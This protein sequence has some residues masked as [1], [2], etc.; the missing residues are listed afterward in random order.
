MIEYKRCKRD[1]YLE[2][3]YMMFKNCKHLF[4]QDWRMKK[5][6]PGRFQQLQTEKDNYCVVAYDDGLPVGV[7]GCIET[8][9]G[10]ILGKQIVVDPR[11]QKQGIGTRLI[12]DMEKQLKEYCQAKFYTIVCLDGTAAIYDKR[13]LKP[14]KGPLKEHEG[15]KYESHYLVPLQ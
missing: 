6:S 14:F 7:F 11:Y 12:E 15:I 9:T 10:R 5:V 1:E 8:N 3:W 13:G 2:A 4:K